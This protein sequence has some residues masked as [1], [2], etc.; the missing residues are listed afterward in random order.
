MC[1]KIVY[2]AAANSGI[3]VICGVGVQQETV[4]NEDEFLK[5]LWIVQQ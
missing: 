1:R 4:Q 3:D 5:V 2:F